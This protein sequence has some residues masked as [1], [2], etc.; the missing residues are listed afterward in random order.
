MITLSQNQTDQMKIQEENG[1]HAAVDEQLKSM[2]QKYL[3]KKQKM[4]A[5]IGED[6]QQLDTSKNQKPD[7]KFVFVPIR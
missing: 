3:T 4:Q 6:P 2:L 7:P 5:Q 1:D